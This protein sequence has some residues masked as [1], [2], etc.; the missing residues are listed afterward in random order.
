MPM[1]LV[2]GYLSGILGVLANVP[3]II[4]TLKGK[5]KPHRVS[6]AIFLLINLINL[7]SLMASGATN[8]LWLV[9]GFSISQ[10]VIVVLSIKKG[11]GGLGR[12]EVTCMIGAGLGIGLWMYFN[13][14]LV[15]IICNII[16]VSI[17]L[18]PTII[19]AYKEPHTETKSTWLIGALGA[20]LSA[21]SVGG[22]HVE[23]LL[24]PIYS[25]VVQ[26]FVYCLLEYRLV[27]LRQPAVGDGKLLKSLNGGSL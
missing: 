25:C 21:L 22:L 2:L 20:L 15:A 7:V 9:I 27:K 14:P 24:F 8:S 6:W 18:V 17:A 5:T 19:K 26:V 4:D 12:L 13:N 10:F 1:L 16:A 11:T 23:L 3:Y